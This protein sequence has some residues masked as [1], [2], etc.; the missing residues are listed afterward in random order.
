[1]PGAD[2]KFAVLYTICQP[3]LTDQIVSEQRET[4]THGVASA[5]S[6]LGGGPADA[7]FVLAVLPDV[8]KVCH[9]ASA[10]RVSRQPDT[11]QV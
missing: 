11:G 2:A 5:A 1:M 6:K 10:S 4:N 7:E 3:N 8:Y 9:A